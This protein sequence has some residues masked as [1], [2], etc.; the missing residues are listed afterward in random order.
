MTNYE[1]IQNMSINK[2]AA[3]FN[4]ISTYFCD[5]C[6]NCKECPFNY[7]GKRLCNVSGFIDWLN[8]EVEE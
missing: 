7:M 3:E 8:S 5:Y 1:K 4:E 2:M 6:Y